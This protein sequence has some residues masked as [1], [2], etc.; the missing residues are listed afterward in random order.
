MR[1]FAVVTAISSTF[2]LPALAQEGGFYVGA[3]LGAVLSSETDATYTPAATAGSTG[4]ISTDNS[5]GFTGSALAGYDFGMF[6][7]EAEAGFISADVDKLKSSFALGTSL[8][9]GSQDAE[10]DVSARTLMANAL[11]DVGSF[12]DFAFFVGGGAGVANLKVS[13]LKAT[14]A[15]GLLLDDKDDDWHSAW[16]GIVG[17]RRSL[18]GN[19]DLQVRYRYFKMDEAEMVG[20]GGRAVA[21]DLS[22]HSL[23]AGVT[24]NF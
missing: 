23:L 18:S 4:N 19:A 6:R 5:L 15:P 10:G 14:A 9:A 3:D 11:L 22:G 1:R 16:Q 12:S 24:Y 20:Q 17:V 13:E 7:V 8:I 21:V 2:A